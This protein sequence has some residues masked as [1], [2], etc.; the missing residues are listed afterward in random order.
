[1]FQEK[2]E[3]KIPVQ[4]LNKQLNKTERKWNIVEKEM[5]AIFY[6]LMKLEHL[7]RDK[8]FVLR[9]DSQILSRMNTAHKEKI[10]RW[11]IAIQHYDFKVQHIK[12]IDN[13]EA[14]A[15]SRLVPLEHDAEM[16]VLV[17]N[18]TIEKIS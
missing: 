5:Y 13:V 7:L 17:Q 8:R 15:L 1:M 12:G 16:H 10:R 6:T 3:K 4:F 9:I 18:D 11:K 2:N 14:D